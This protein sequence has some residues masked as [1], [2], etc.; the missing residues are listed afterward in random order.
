[1]YTSVQANNPDTLRPLR[2]FVAVAEEL[3]FGRAADR[4]ILPQSTVSE[5]V[6]L[7]EAHVG[8]TLF[9]RTT[10]SVRLTPLGEVLLP[11]ATRALDAVAHAYELAARTAR[12]GNVAFLLGVAIDIDAGELADAFVALRER[13]TD[14]RVVPTPMP[15]VAQ[16]DALRDRRI[17]AGFVWEPPDRDGIEQ[18]LVGVTGMIAIVPYDHALAV[19]DRLEVGELDEYPLVLFSG[20]PN[21]W[22][23]RRFD[24]ICAEHGISP[25]VV[26]E[27]VGYE[28]QA[29]LVLAGTGIGVTAASI[30]TTRAIPGLVHV[31]VAV[32]SG[33]RRSLIWHRDETHPGLSTLRD[34]LREHRRS[35][36]A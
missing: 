30:G 21:P 5:Q 15:T 10:R 29:G 35:V 23:R 34:L 25:H 22:V 24:T 12:T 33:W 16:L 7:L 20:A 1:M 26:A 31:P 14:L 13:H 2:C 3:H 17:H 28:G 6:R 11:A 18:Q 19:R 27:G 36:T 4:L 32:R 8:G 9:A